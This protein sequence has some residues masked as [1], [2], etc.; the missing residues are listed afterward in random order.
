MCFSFK[1][2][3]FSIYRSQSIPTSNEQM[4]ET[5][6]RTF[7][8]KQL[9]HKETFKK[10]LKYSVHMTKALRKTSGPL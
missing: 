7:A 1:K 4:M 10:R 2:M 5:K 8:R 6:L 9:L 3:Q